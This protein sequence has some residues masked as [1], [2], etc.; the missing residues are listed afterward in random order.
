MTD[1]KRP[2]HRNK[3]RT[4]QCPIEECSAEPLARGIHL[5][6]RRSDGGG[7]GPCGEVPEGVDFNDLETVGERDVAMA[8]PEERDKETSPR[9][10]PYCLKPF[11]GTKGVLIHLGQ[12]AGQNMHPEDGSESVDARIFPAVRTDDL[13]QVTGVINEGGSGSNIRD[14]EVELLR[15]LFFQIADRCARD[16]YEEAWEL[17]RLIPI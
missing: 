6:V 12:V 15:R 16:D 7:H 2:P 1:R 5:H 10:C 9:L 13:G 4:V 14:E 17:R 3:E 8:Y 11:N